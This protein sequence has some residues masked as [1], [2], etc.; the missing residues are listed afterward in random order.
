[1]LSVLKKTVYQRSVESG[2][3][4]EYRKTYKK[5]DQSPEV[6]TGMEQSIAFNLRN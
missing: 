6:V 2:K 3:E 4:K 1:M 5:M